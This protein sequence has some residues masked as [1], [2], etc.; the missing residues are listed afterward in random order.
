[1]VYVTNPD[2]TKHHPTR[3]AVR[4]CVRKWGKAK[5]KSPGGPR[6]TTKADDQKILK[7]VK[8]HRAK[9]YVDAAVVHRCL[10]KR[11]RT[12]PKAV[13]THT[14]GNRIRDDGYRW[15]DKSHK[16][17]LPSAS[18]QKRMNWCT[19]NQDIDSEAWLRRVQACGDFK[20]YT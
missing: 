13:T 11:L 4:E 6:K 10:P 17:E 19:D 20:D 5:K 2:G 14:I 18:E 7:L 16:P 1:M 8:K 3:R 15:T 9:G 12:G